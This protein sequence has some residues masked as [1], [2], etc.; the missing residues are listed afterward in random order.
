MNVSV[1]VNPLTH[2]LP[3]D[4]PNNAYFAV[5]DG[6]GGLDAAIYASQHLHSNMVHHPSFHTDTESAMHDSFRKTDDEFLKKAKYEV[7]IL[8]R[9]PFHYMKGGC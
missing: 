3:Q 8:E 9:T 7:G 1:S 2:L 5:F 6:H 4:C